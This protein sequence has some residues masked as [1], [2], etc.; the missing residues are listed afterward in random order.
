MPLSSPK[1][2]FLTRLFF[3][4]PSLLHFYL[5][6]ADVEVRSAAVFRNAENRQPAVHMYKIELLEGNEKA[7]HTFRIFSKQFLCCALQFFNFKKYIILTTVSVQFRR[8]KCRYKTV[9]PSLQA[10]FKLFI[11][12]NKRQPL[13]SNFPIAS[14][15]FVQFPCSGHR[16]SGIMQ[17]L[18]F[19]D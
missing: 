16:R 12:P 15:H 18:P 6:I 9:S 2:Q 7:D 8:M 5:E 3:F 13:S 17:C 14:P 11:T 19:C 10:I 4:F 1:S